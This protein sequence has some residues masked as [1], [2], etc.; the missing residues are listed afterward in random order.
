MGAAENQ[1]SAT[2]GAST[3]RAGRHRRKEIDGQFSLLD[4]RLQ[5]G[6]LGSWNGKSCV[7][8]NVTP[9]ERSIAG[10]NRLEGARHQAGDVR[11]EH[12]AELLQIVLEERGQSGER[13]EPAAVPEMAAPERS[14]AVDAQ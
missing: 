10:S 11:K 2:L 1:V 7:A 13:D 6:R 4:E 12:R 8:W 14:A 3:A 9:P 5:N